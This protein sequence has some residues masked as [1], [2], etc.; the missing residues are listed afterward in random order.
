MARA[1]GTVLSAG[2]SEGLRLKH[3]WSPDH[4][5]GHQKAFLCPVASKHP[6]GLVLIATPYLVGQRWFWLSM[7]VIRA[8]VQGDKPPST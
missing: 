3:P 6:L 2:D 1:R 5:G 7:V 8:G 4:T